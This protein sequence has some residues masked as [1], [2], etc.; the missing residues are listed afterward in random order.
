MESRKEAVIN[1]DELVDMLG[2]EERL[3]LTTQ[4]DKTLLMASLHARFL[5]NPPTHRAELL[6][7]P[8]IP[9][10]RTWPIM[11]AVIRELATFRLHRKFMNKVGKFVITKNI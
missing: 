6:R 3:G 10:L 1:Y 7:H 9:V 11:D 4:A 2:L 8:L 5:R